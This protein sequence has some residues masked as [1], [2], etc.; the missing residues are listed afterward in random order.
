MS[1][2]DEHACAKRTRVLLLAPLCR[3]TCP[4][5]SLRKS[6]CSCT[7]ALLPRTE[8]RLEE[9]LCGGRDGRGALACVVEYF[10]DLFA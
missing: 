1:E 9:W 8:R 3:R 2:C 7:T 4:G 10:F 6:T 5:R